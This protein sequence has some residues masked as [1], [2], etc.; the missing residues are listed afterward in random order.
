M[1]I[2]DNIFQNDKWKKGL[3][4]GNVQIQNFIFTILGVVTIIEMC[5]ELRKPKV[6]FDQKYFNSF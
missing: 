5:D 1:K 3:I 4:N 2:I 6:K